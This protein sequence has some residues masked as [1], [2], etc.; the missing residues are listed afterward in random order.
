MLTQLH[1]S[2][3]S[4]GRRFRNNGLFFQH[5]LPPLHGPDHASSRSGAVLDE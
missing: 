1:G 3:S 5:G 2:A 4:V